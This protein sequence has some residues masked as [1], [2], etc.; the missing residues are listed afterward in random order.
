MTNA[1]AAGG[2]NDGL[3]DPLAWLPAQELPPMVPELLD[4]ERILLNP[5]L[6]RGLLHSAERQE[7]SLTF[8][9]C[10]GYYR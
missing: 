7:H 3:A 1:V 5:S 4:E 6:M 10:R 8:Y 9:K 2:W